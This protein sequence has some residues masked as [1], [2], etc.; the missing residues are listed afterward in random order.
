MYS[1]SSTNFFTEP[2]V[3]NG[4]GLDKFF[5]D[6]NITV[7]GGTVLI[8][9]KTTGGVIYSSSLTNGNL[10]PGLINNIN[11]PGVVSYSISGKVLTATGTGISG[12]TISLSDSITATATTDSNG[13]YSVIGVP[14][15]KYTLTASNA[16]YAFDPSSTPIT[17]NGANLTAQNF[18]G[19]PVQFSPTSFSISGTVA[20]AAG[21]GISGV[22]V[23]LVGA[24]TSTA[25]TNSSGNYTFTGAINGSY[26]ITVASLSYTFSQSSLPVTV[27]NSNL[28][29]RN[30]TGTLK[31]PASYTI[32]GTVA[33]AAGVGIPNVTVT[34]SGTGNSTAT[35]NTDGAF[36][37]SGA[38]NGD[39]SLSAS[40]SSYTFAPTYVTLPV[41]NANVIGQNFTGT[42]IPRT[43]SII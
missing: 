37:I 20:S 25:T 39:Y 11:L 26:T 43:Y 16:S 29:G 34:L 36:S 31:P 32:S 5:A 15:G 30:F 42:I 38:T 41:N 19:A 8:S 28:A 10:I 14:N 4:Q 6:V 35:T 27:N 2:F 12:I 13:S 33:T 1:V 24:S 40:N 18:T 7:Q 21:T 9:N 3:A 23:S 17:V 22:T